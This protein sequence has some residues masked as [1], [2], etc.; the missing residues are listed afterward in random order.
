MT[1]KTPNF[2]WMRK[3]ETIKQ[4]EGRNPT[5]VIL[6]THKASTWPYLRLFFAEDIKSWSSKEGHR[7]DAGPGKQVFSIKA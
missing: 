7:N 5:A 1:K 3:P 2:L 6:N 4:R